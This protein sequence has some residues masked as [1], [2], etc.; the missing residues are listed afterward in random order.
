MSKKKGENY[1]DTFVELVGYSCKA[2]DLLKEIVNDYN[3]E[4]LPQK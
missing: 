4:M 1:F 2:A 3:A